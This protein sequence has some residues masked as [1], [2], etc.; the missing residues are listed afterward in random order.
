MDDGSI[1]N[2]VRSNLYEVQHQ[3]FSVPRVKL[4]FHEVGFHRK[5]YYT[6]SEQD[7]SMN[8]WLKAWT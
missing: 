6:T 2:T 5:S 7:D 8:V 1:N 4:K 3:Q